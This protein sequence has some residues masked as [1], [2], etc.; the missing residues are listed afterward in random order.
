MSLFFVYLFKSSVS[1]AL[2]YIVF[3][4]VMRRDKNHSLNRFLLLG[5]LAASA[6]IPLL[7]FQL[8]REEVVIQPVSVIRDFIYTPVEFADISQ[9]TILAEPVQKGIEINWWLL[10]YSLAIVVLFARLV[11]SLVRVIQLVWG[12]EKMPLKKYIIAVI[13]EMVQPFSFLHYI[14]ISEKDFKT[15]KEEVIA[16]EQEHIRQKHSIDLLVCELFT[17]LHWF[18]PFMWLLRRDLKMVHEFQ[19]DQAV[20]NTGID[21]KKYQ[22]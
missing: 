17:L 18:N 8:F 12:S 6:I 3:R 22:L 15:N 5:I 13:K 16:H 9:P 10:A 19:A 14:V 2:F 11:I 7:N 4:L 21:A 1:L 20:L